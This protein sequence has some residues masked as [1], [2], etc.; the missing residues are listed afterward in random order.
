MASDFPKEWSEILNVK[1]IAEKTF[2]LI[3]YL[4]KKIKF[5][6]ALWKYKIGLFN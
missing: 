1:L 3:K 2:N 6:L 4:I 5:V